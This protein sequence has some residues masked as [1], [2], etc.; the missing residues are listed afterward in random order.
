MDFFPV[1]SL[2]IKTTDILSRYYSSVSKLQD[3]IVAENPETDSDP[4]HLGDEPV[5]PTYRR[6]KI[7]D[8]IRHR[9]ILVPNKRLYDPHKIP[10]VHCSNDMPWQSPTG[11]FM[12]KLLIVKSQLLKEFAVIT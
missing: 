11:S 12:V 9:N 1:D 10:K 3:Q 5:G 6:H 7:F 2:S 4:S 8:P